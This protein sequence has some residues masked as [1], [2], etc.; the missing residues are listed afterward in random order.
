MLGPRIPFV[1]N[2]AQNVTPTSE[3]GE[4]SELACKPT[5]NGWVPSSVK[6]KF[7]LLSIFIQKSKYLGGNS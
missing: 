4:V 5:N 3:K 1:R 7:S 6:E 2:G